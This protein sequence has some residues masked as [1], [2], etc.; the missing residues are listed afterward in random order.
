MEADPNH[1]FVYKKPVI[2]AAVT[3]ALRI[4]LIK[5]TDF[6]ENSESIVQLFN[7][8]KHM[9]HILSFDIKMFSAISIMHFENSKMIY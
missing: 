6:P 4:V 9:R 2:V 8:L 7:L 5:D 3:I 1:K